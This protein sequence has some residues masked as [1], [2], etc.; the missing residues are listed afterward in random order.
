MGVLGNKHIPAEYL[1]ASEAQRRALLAGLLDTDGYALPGGTVQFAVTSQRLAQGVL[2]LVLSLGYRASM[3]TKPVRG[4]TPGS[5]TSYIITFTPDREVFRLRRKAVRQTAGLKAARSRYVTDVRP[6]PSVPVRCVQVDSPDHMYLASRSW[7]PTHNS[8]LALDLARAATVKHGLPCVIFSLEMGRNE[9]TMRLLSA[10][11]RVPLHS[12]RTG[13]MSDEDW[14]RLARRMSEVV[15]AP[16]YIDDSPNMSM[17][18]IRA[19]C[20]R[21]KQRHDLKLVII[22]YLQL[23]S[24][25]KRVENRQQEVSEMSRSLKLL[26][27]ELDVPVIAV[28]QLNRGPE[29][30]TDKKPLL[31]DLRESGS[32]E[33]DADMVILL[34]REDAYERESPRA[35]EADFIVAKHRNGPTATVTV[36]FQGHFSRFVDMAP[37]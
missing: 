3:T 35:G 27:K 34:H 14:T 25:P 7:I 31:S 21:L 18:E 9:I 1:R 6:V 15:E 11:A 32:I 8:T 33:Q 26:A 5:S 16:L 30:R 29:Q 19:K 23:M 2:E 28:A 22:D 36:A 24:S 37:G 13:Q 4:R 12:M 17:M 20:R 10:E